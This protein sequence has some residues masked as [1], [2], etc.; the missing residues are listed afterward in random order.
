MNN[1]TNEDAALVVRVPRACEMLAMSK[2]TLYALLRKGEI[3]SYREEGTRKILLSSIKAYVGKRLEEN[4][5]GS[6][7]G[8]K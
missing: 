3:E 6:Q 5:W 2:P 7:A 8:R 1:T 4:R